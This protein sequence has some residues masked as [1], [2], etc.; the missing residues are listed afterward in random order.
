MWARFHIPCYGGV[1][2]C[3]RQSLE[4]WGRLKCGASSILTEHVAPSAREVSMLSSM[5]PS[6]RI[7]VDLQQA[8][9]QRCSVCF[10]FCGC[11]RNWKSKKKFSISFRR[12]DSKRSAP[13][14]A[15]FAKRATPHAIELF[16]VGQIGFKAS[17]PSSNKGSVK[18]LKVDNFPP[19]FDS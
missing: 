11:L 19:K 2:F 3:F 4:V 14:A 10:D 15:M 8:L 6:R 17:F 7:S 13:R 5:G 1:Y 16:F 18:F 12:A 9:I